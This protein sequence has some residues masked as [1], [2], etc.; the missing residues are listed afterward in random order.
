MILLVR[1]VLTVRVRHLI[2]FE[3]TKRPALV[4]R[5][6]RVVV[7]VEFGALRFEVPSNAPHAIEAARERFFNRVDLWERVGGDEGG[8][9]ER[10]DEHGEDARHRVGRDGRASMCEVR[11]TVRV[12]RVKVSLRLPFRAITISSD[13]VVFSTSFSTV[14]LWRC[15]L[16]LRHQKITRNLRVGHP[17]RRGRRGPWWMKIYDAFLTPRTLRPRR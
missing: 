7:R 6:R 3:R 2:G 1:I 12:G 4:A 16:R 17:P 15:R 14:W 10:G 5:A 8:A 11:V 13:D 9:C